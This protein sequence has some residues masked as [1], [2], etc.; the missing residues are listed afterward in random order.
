MR[1]DKEYARIVNGSEILAKE[2]TLYFVT[3]TCRGDIT[4]ETALQNYLLWSDRLLTSMRNEAKCRGEHWA[5][6]QVTEPQKRKHPHSH[7]I[8]CSVPKDAKFIVDHWDE[9]LA[10]IASVNAKIPIQMRFSPNPKKE[11]TH[12]DMYSEWFMLACV[13]AGLGVQC[14]ISVVDIA[15]AVSRYVAKYLFKVAMSA[16]WARNWRR[17]RYSQSFP[18][19]P[20]YDNKKAFPV[21]TKEDWRRVERITETINTDDVIVYHMAM[22][23]H[24]WNIRLISDKKTIDRQK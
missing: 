8:M 1:A 17:V 10:T 12:T 24:V 9:Y 20:E 21:M 3:V 4:L 15:A 13:R 5:Y 19:L 2:N 23:R 6:V 14:R 18:K 11:Y 16:K 7:I 22:V